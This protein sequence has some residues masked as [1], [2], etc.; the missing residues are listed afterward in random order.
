MTDTNMLKKEI[1]RSGLKYKYVAEQLGL[2]PY[3]LQKKI[4]NMTEFKASEIR[5]L[6]EIL[7]LTNE[8][9][10]RIFFATMLN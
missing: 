1:A 5:S 6:T 9:R 8:K 3:G 10:D 4:K 2:T 7:G